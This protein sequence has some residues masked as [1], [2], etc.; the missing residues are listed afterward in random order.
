[1]QSRS[2]SSSDWSKPGN[3]KFM[4]HFLTASDFI[5]FI[6]LAHFARSVRK[7]MKNVASM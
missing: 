6:E 3:A 4:N 2:I 5:I 1:M 7:E